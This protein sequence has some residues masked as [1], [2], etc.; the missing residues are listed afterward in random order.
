M[1]KKIILIICLFVLTGCSKTYYLNDMSL[2]DI[3][4]LNVSSVNDLSNVNNKG[5]RYNL[6]VGFSVYSDEDYNQILL[7]N[8]NKYYLNVDI[9][10]YYYR[11]SI[12]SSHEIDD[13]KYYIFSNGDKNGYLR[14]TKNNDYFFVELCYNYAIIEV[15]VKES[16]LRYA[17]SRSIVILN[18][19]KY[20]DLVIERYI[21]DNDLESSETVYSIPEPEEKNDSKNVLQWIDESQEQN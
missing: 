7:S 8:N 5:Y 14:I 20:N 19:I 11:N 18:S 16:E 1:Y 9:V 13:Y 12:S 10:G 15:E 4:N 3:I 2:E 17:V 6:P 21:D